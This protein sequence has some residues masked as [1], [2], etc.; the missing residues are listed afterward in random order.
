MI[1][2]D[3]SSPPRVQAPPLRILKSPAAIFVAAFVIRV[4][5]FLIVLRSAPL[6]RLWQTGYEASCIAASLLSGHGFSSPFGTPTGPTAWVP[7]GYVGILAILFQAFGPYSAPAASLALLLNALFAAGTAVAIYAAGKKIRRKREG[8][9]AAWIWALSP[10]TVVMSL[11]IWETSLSA[12]LVMTGSLLYWNLQDAR[13]RKDWGLWGAFWG[14]AAL[15]NPALLIFFVV[16]SLGAVWRQS[17]QRSRRLAFAATLALVF[18]APWTARNYLRFHTFIPIR[19]NFGEELWLGNH[20]GVIL[21]N[22][23]TL[24]P[25]GNRSELALYRA[26]GESAYVAEKRRAAIAFICSHPQEFLYLTLKRVA[27]FWSSP[28][29]KLWIPISLLSFF[30]LALAVKH[31]FLEALPFAVAL[32]LFPGTYYLTHADNWYR[33]PIEPVMALMFVF[34]I[35]GIFPEFRGAD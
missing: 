32:L 7:P 15:V 25:L 9:I 1:S 34:A 31:D 14:C 26:L 16:L 11:K 23:E 20:R 35:T 5:F 24:H 22:D 21:P 8:T 2:Q 6:N 4:G 17:R 18:V 10:Y 19:S 28:D 33:D 27:F 13:S 29:V 3:V 12:L 30:G